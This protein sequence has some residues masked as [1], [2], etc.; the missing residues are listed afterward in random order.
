MWY[1]RMLAGHRPEAVGSR[2]EL[3]TRDKASGRGRLG[4]AGGCWRRWWSLA[5][6]HRVLGAPTHSLCAQ[7]SPTLCRDI[8]EL[9]VG[10]S[11]AGALTL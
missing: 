10:R 2:A 1:A 5:R 6:G 4:C 11:G 9:E 7:Q 8:T 3:S